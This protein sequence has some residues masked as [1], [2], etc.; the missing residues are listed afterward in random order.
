LTQS[1][2][3]LDGYF[4][5]GGLA[6]DRYLELTYRERF[7]ITQSQYDDEPL[8]AVLYWLAVEERRSDVRERQRQED[9]TTHG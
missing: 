8:E 6:P 9:P 7:H 2:A 3:D 1:L 4:Y 5:A